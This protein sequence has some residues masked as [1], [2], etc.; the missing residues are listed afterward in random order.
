MQPI[1]ERITERLDSL[2]DTLRPAAYG[3]LFIVLFML[4]RGAW[5]VARGVGQDI[6]KENRWNAA[7]YPQ[8]SEKWLSRDR[9]WHNLRIPV[10]LGIIVMANILYFLIRPR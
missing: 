10:W 1:L 3:A 4:M 2:S 7:L 6:S 8:G 9:A 5:L